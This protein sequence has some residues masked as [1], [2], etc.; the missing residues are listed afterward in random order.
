M[1]VNSVSESYNGY[2]GIKLYNLYVIIDLN[3]LLKDF[4]SEDNI[5]LCDS[6][7]N[8]DTEYNN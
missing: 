8:R 1:K 2:V 4:L 5:E 6:R 7:K 3:T